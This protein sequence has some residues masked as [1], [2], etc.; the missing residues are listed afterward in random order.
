MGRIQN[1]TRHGSLYEDGECVAPVGA[2]CDGVAY[3]T[4]MNTVGIGNPVPSTMGGMGSGDLYP[5][6]G[7]IQKK[8]RWVRKK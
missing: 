8:R 7:G 6:L 1:N 2:P 4:L 3:N 5:S